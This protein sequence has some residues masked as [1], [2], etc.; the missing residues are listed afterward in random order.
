MENEKRLSIKDFNEKVAIFEGNKQNSAKKDFYE[1]IAMFETSNRSSKKL[2]E[3]KDKNKGQLDDS[4][5][6]LYNKHIDQFILEKLK[7]YYKPSNRKSFS[8]KNSTT[9]SGENAK[10]KIEKIN[11]NNSKRKK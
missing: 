2:K 11:N 3:K 5:N 9:N 6:K 10:N 8:Q 4:K 7:I 1:K